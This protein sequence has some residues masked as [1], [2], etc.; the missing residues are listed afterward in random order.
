M[1]PVSAAKLNNSIAAQARIR[2]AEDS[3]GVPFIKVSL[4]EGDRVILERDVEMGKDI[5]IDLAMMIRRGP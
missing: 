4:H 3:D 2:W 5:K 1:D